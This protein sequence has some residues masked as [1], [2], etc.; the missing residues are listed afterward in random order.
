MMSPM[1]MPVHHQHQHGYGGQQH[2]ASNPM[3]MK[4]DVPRRNPS[5]SGERNERTDR[6]ERRP[7][8]ASPEGKVLEAGMYGM[9]HRHGMV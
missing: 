9:G 4:P 8:P 1:L 6:R 2:H 7:R 3:D 5:R